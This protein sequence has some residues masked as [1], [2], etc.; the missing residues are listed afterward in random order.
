MKEHFF[1]EKC[2]IFGVY[3]EGL[4]ASRLT[5]F[6]LF[7]LQHRGQE[8]SGI[9]SSDGKRINVFKDMGL[10]SHVYNEKA[11]KSLPGHMAVGHN[12]YSTSKSS[13]IE[14]AQPVTGNHKFLH[15]LMSSFKDKY[16]LVLAH[17]GNLPST[18]KLE[19]FFDDRKIKTEEFNDSEL[20]AEAIRYYMLKGAKLEDALVESYPLFTGVFSL[21]IMTKDKIAAVRDKCG[22]RPFSLGK[23]D[24]GY[25]F[26]SETCALDTVNAYY[27]KDVA[28]GEMV[29][30]DKDG[31]YCYQIENGD[32]KLDI[33]E[34]VY[35]ARPDSI[36]LGKRVSEV[37]RN[38]GRRLAREHHIEGDVIVPVPDSATYAAEGYSEMSGIPLRHGL[39]KN[40]YIHRTFIQPGQRLRE[41]DV[42]LKLNPIPE[43]LSG[44]RVVVIDDSIVRGTT[45]QRIVNML[46]G[47]GASEVYILISS[48]PY[49]FPDWYGIDTPYQRRLIA[50]TRNNEEIREFIGADYLGYLSYQG[51]IDA[52]GLP[53]TVFSTSCFSG[54]YPIDIGEKT[55]EIEFRELVRFS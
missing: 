22:I 46:R 39:I 25:V 50:A 17:N 37:R 8:S 21:L 30:A 55:G 23:L 42:E 16:A 18:T 7:A 19:K 33:F 54:I 32:Q 9:A 40:R 41:R 6:G 5:Y 10:V 51:L 53:E 2:G 24:G 11:L 15:K 36:L 29:I 47:K 27:V 4:E 38:F 26:S 43:V 3:G 34:F 35:F 49:R 12:R 45:S 44:K 20:M 1:G 31:L 14:H 48:P 13:S 52:T 28:P